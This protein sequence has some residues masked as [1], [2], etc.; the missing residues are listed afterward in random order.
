ML[1]L[2]SFINFSAFAGLLYYFGKKPARHFW[3]VRRKNVFDALSDAEA[4]Y[5]RATAAKDAIDNKLRS[6]ETEIAD[7]RAQFISEGR[8]HKDNLIA[9]AKTSSDKMVR[10][11]RLVIEHEIRKATLELERAAVLK[12]V[13]LAEERLVTE[14]GT[15]QRSKLLASAQKE[16]E[17]NI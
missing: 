4:A 15:K 14:M 12:A 1:S 7:L 3:Q 8:F 5:K 10:E 6:I 17:S 2:F 13:R 16:I 11:A 9:S